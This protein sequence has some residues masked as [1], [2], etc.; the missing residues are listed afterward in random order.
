MT[1]DITDFQGS[2]VI[3]VRDVIARVE[4]LREEREASEIPAN[5]YGGPN[6]TWADERVELATL[7]SLLS[8]MKGYGGDEQWKGDW[9]PTTLIND[10][11]FKTSMDELVEDCCDIPRDLPSYLTITIDYKALQSDYTAVE[12]NGDTYWYR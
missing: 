3:D 4:E 2:D 5:E 9:Y 11:Y 6:D 1:Q 12:F 7:E 10:S 8:D